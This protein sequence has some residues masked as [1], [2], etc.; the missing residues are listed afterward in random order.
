MAISKKT[1]FEVFKR[2]SFTCQYCGRKAP[3]V[4]LEIDHVHPKAEGGTDDLMNLITA[5]R[6]CNRGKGPRTLSDDSVIE[7]RRRQLEELQE[8]KEQI[9]MMV[10][11]QRSLADVE[12]H[13]TESVSGFW[14]GLLNDRFSLTESGQRE[15]RKL[16]D[17]FGLDELLEAMRIAVNRYVEHDEEGVPTSE[18]VGNA[19][20][21]LGGICFNRK[22]YRE[23][24]SAEAVD[25]AFAVFL[26]AYRTN[27]S[28]HPE[29]W[30]LKRWWLTNVA[31][32][33]ESR[34]L[35]PEIAHRLGRR[36]VDMCI[37]HYRNSDW[38]SYWS[39]L[40]DLPEEFELESLLDA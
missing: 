39:A 34:D 36:V 17:R 6:E 15:V 40:Q 7:K 21:K 2:D 27:C 30:A 5:C 4:I 26:N 19:F 24:P 11:W 8:R 22:R 20:D 35:S 18:S 37:D 16:I 3:D 32:L 13:A 14:S 31:P 9:E 25:R 12:G 1:R 29:R 23:D 38:T 28:Y 10:E 33:I